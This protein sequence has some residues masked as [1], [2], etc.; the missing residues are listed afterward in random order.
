MMRELPRETRAERRCSNVMDRARMEAGVAS[1]AGTHFSRQESDE[2]Q[3]R[4]LGEAEWLKQLPLCVLERR[5]Y[6]IGG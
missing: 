2:S 4:P 3:P 6:R 5:I 1:A